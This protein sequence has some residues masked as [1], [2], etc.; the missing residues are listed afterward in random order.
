MRRII[1]ID[2]G[3]TVGFFE[4][5]VSNHNALSDAYARQ[6]PWHEFNEYLERECAT[7][8]YSNMIVEKFTITVETAKKSPQPRALMVIGVCEWFARR[9]GIPFD[10]TQQPSTVM[11]MVTDDVLKAVDFYTP[12][13]VHA[14]DAARHAVAWLLKNNVIPPESVLDSLDS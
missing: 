9:A 12:G 7:L 5:W 11:R 1:A 8:P 6:L 3:E 13:A 14:N 2:P 10:N 4:V